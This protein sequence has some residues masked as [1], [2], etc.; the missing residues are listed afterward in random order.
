M[1]SI[2]FPIIIKR[3]TT[4][5]TLR[6]NIQLCSEAERTNGN[7]GRDPQQE[8]SCEEL[9]WFLELFVGHLVSARG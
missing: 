8:V 4:P 9:G 1:T 7:I 5:L 3:R 2:H 6:V